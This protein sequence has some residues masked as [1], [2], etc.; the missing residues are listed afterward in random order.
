MF[1]FLV[2]IATLLPLLYYIGELSIFNGA[3]KEHNTIFV[4]ILILASLAAW[5]ILAVR[6]LNYDPVLLTSFFEV[7]IGNFKIPICFKIDRIVLFYIF[8]N[9]CVFLHPILVNLFYKNNTS[10]KWFPAGLSAMTVVILAGNILVLLFSMTLL[11]LGFLIDDI[12]S[13]DI[14]ELSK[15]SE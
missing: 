1:S 15:Q 7:E 11:S 14:N 5:I 2:P 13:D 10:F 3:K 4:L 9:I 8:A 12:L 6:A